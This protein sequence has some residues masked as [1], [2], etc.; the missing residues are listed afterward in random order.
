M[1]LIPPPKADPPGP[2][3]QPPAKPTTPGPS[4]EVQGCAGTGTR[5][6]QIRRDQLFDTDSFVTILD[7]IRKALDDPT[8]T[9]EEACTFHLDTSALLENGE[10]CYEAVFDLYVPADSRFAPAADPAWVQYEK[11]YAEYQKDRAAWKK[12][13]GAY[14]RWVAFL[15]T[16]WDRAVPQ[17]EADVRLAQMKLDEVKALH[18]RYADDIEAAFAFKNEE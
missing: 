9:P 14:S 13:A 8:V 6:A 10:Y 16:L 7:V 18:E 3:P 12:R 15:R 5:W 1:F 4:V 2:K 11:D 17:A